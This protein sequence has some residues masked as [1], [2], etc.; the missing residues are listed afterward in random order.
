MAYD[1]KSMTRTASAPIS[2]GRAI[3]QYLYITA[4][5]F[6]AV[7]AAAYFNADAKRLKKGDIID[8]SMSQGGTPTTTRL[9][10]TSADGV[11]PVT[12]AVAI[13]A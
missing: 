7:S 9:V 1:P 3:S 8:C 5:A 12:T 13:F 11:T 2:A 6:A 4:D 10:V